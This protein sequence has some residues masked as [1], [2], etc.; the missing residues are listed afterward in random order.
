MKLDRDKLQD[1]M[2][3]LYREEHEALGEAGTDRL[4]EWAT[5]GATSSTAWRPKATVG[6]QVRYSATSAGR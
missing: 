2:H 3:K 4:L 1:D 5:I 6:T